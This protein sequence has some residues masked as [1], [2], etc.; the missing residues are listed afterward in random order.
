MQQRI[1]SFFLLLN[2]TIGKLWELADNV[3]TC[4]DLLLV[5]VVLNRQGT[6][7]GN[8][9]IKF[10][11]QIDL[12]TSAQAEYDFLRI[13]DAHPAVYMD[14]VIHYAI[15][16]YEQYWLL[17]VAENQEKPLPAPLDIE[18]VWHCHILNPFLYRSDC[19]KIVNRFVDH[20]PYKLCQANR[21]LSE[22]YWK[23]KYPDIP[24]DTDLKNAAP[25]L[26]DANYSQKSQYDIASATLRHV[27]LTITRRYHITEIKSFSK[28]QHRGIIKCSR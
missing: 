19:Y 14:P 27:H 8:K 15:Y 5:L 7:M 20:C 4:E 9:T 25:P 6:K 13:V 2:V 3:K 12:V 23:E 10:P 17:L 16:R 26:I 28:R 24:F 18:W 1:N 22:R 11:S 21:S